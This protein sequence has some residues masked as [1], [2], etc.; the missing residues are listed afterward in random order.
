MSNVRR[1]LTDSFEPP[2]KFLQPGLRSR[3][4][5]KLVSPIRK[6]CPR[7]SPPGLA[8]VQRPSESEAETVGRSGRH[9]VID[10]GQATTTENSEEAPDVGLLSASPLPPA[11]SACELS[12]DRG[13]DETNVEDDERS[14]ANIRPISASYVQS[15]ADGYETAVRVLVSLGSGNEPEHSSIAWPSFA[16][17]Q[18]G[19]GTR[20][21]GSLQYQEARLSLESSDTPDEMQALQLLTRFRY[22]VAQWV[23]D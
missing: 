12:P 21:S 22:V 5:Q 16:E 10:N 23:R 6:A 14:T 19:L 11:E 20:A 9:G 13:A 4:K 2:S 17:G 15:P 7:N 3:R 8:P 1:M 18:A